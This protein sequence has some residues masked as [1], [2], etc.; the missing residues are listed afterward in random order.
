MRWTVVR[1]PQIVAMAALAV[2]CASNMSALLAASSSMSPAT[3]GPPNGA[4]TSP[5]STGVARWAVDMVVE[6]ALVPFSSWAN[7]KTN[8]GAAGDGVTD[9]T[10]ALQRALND[11]GQPGKAQVLYLPAGTYR[12]SATLNWTG[13]PQSGAGSFGW[14][15]LGLIGADPATTTI[16]WAGPSGQ[17]ML[18]Q[19]GGLGYRYERLTWDGSSTAGYGVAHWWNANG[20]ALYG[21]SVEHQDEVF[22][23]MQIGIMAGRMGANYRQMD[24]EG[25]VR[26]VTFINN[27]YAGLDTGSFNALDWWVWDSHF[28]N[29]ARGVSNQ[30]GLDSFG[31]TTGAGAFYVYRSFF[32]R[33]SVAD[34]AITNTGW[35]S[36]HN[37]V[38]IGSRR[39]FEAARVGRNPAVVIAQSNRVVQS[40][41]AVPISSGNM[42][43]LLLVDN[44]I[45]A[46]RA[47]YELTAWFTG[48]DALSL[49]NQVTS[50]PPAPAKSDR[51]VSIDDLEVLA[52]DVST[53]PME[54]P[55]TPALSSHQVFEVPA[56]ASA[57]QIQTVINQSLTSGDSQ[58]I[59]H[60]G[61]GSW[62]LNQSLSIPKNASVQLV[63]DGYGS[64]VNWGG[65]S[66][67]MLSIAAPAKVTIRDMQWLG[68]A[69]AIAISGADASGG[70]IQMVAT[71]SG[72]LSATHLEQTQL[73]LQANP[74]IWTVSLS[75]VI[76]A[77][78]IANGGIGT[79]TLANNSSFLMSDTW[80][81]GD[82]ST[83]FSLSSGT[84]TYLGGH[85]SPADH[86]KAGNYP[87]TGQ[88][89]GFSG[90][91]SLIGMELDLN[92]VS[93]GVGIEVT[94][95]TAQTH[96]YLLGNTSGSNGGTQNNWFRRRGA[97]GEVAFN[98]NRESSGQYAD[99]G[100]TS[101]TA[102]SNTWKQARSLNWDSA[103]Y[104]VPAGAVDIRIYHMKM[105]QTA[106]IMI[107]G[108]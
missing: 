67:S 52:T 43:P 50:G 84:F 107:N 12:I 98:L 91:A 101:G 24:S 72:P 56:G 8:Y 54:L 57:A 22:K 61:Q 35:F 48:R 105:D 1:L 94:D 93:S 64:V 95:E 76:N 69:N 47:S 53:Q 13:S 71:S 92:H 38:S 100:D 68:S 25:Q 14:G 96:V 5:G 86:T 77:V 34:V 49:G 87:P 37:N 44:Q 30:Y 99:Q 46:A 59:V 106:G 2:L 97:G 19:N 40:T 41:D 7:A 33:S 9:D 104:E 26:R 4:P 108:R 11:L 31:V 28:V 21:A 88:F 78:A 27:S 83:L 82:M 89:R 6:E 81:E 29:C 65:S 42:G 70:R 63:G 23:N 73:S 17:A 85:P 51:L 66:G 80:Y 103:P 79:V 74:G 75:D 39:F 36:L 60:F 10:A 55:S 90:S 15:G 3:A 20:G 102:I 16:K 62:T 18:I 58:P 45:Q 32:E